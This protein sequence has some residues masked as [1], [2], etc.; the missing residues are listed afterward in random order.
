LDKELLRI[1]IQLNYENK[2]RIV[3]EIEYIL[4]VGDCRNKIDKKKK[5]R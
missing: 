5:D 3:N 2:K 4:K 1:Y